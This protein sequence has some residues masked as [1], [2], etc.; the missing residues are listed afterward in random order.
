M[1]QRWRQTI[2]IRSSED[3]FVDFNRK[4]GSNFET[5]EGGDQVMVST[6]APGLGYQKSNFSPNS[7]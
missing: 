1:A 3:Y 6:R 4:I 5:L 2:R 7:A